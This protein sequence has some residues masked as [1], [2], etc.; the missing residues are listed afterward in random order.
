MRVEF[1]MLGIRYNASVKAVDYPAFGDEPVVVYC[2]R[3]DATVAYLESPE[4]STAQGYAEVAATALA[5]DSL[6]VF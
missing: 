1:S 3:H 2:V 4:V 5:L 6:V